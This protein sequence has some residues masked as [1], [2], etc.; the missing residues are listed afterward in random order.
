MKKYKQLVL[1]ML[2]SAILKLFDIDTI[3]Y[4]LIT[5]DR[6]YEIA[7]DDLLALSSGAKKNS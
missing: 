6:H 5:T 2:V 3:I 1:Y 7:E 4:D